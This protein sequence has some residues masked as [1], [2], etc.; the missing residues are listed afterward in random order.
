MVK[1]MAICTRHPFLHIYKVEQPYFID[2]DKSH[3]L[4]WSEATFITSSRRVFQIA[5]SGNF[6][7]VIRC[8]QLNGL[9]VNAT[10]LDA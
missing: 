2:P 4:T 7:I 9:I 6:R 10:T 1:A 3:K 8:S 5:I